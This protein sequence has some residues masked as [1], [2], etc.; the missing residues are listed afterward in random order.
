[1]YF[2]VVHASLLHRKKIA[3]YRGASDNGKIIKITVTN[4][5]EVPCSGSSVQRVLTFKSEGLT[6]QVQTTGKETWPCIGCGD[7][8]SDHKLWHD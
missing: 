5:V 7:A 2:T 1:M 3:Q 8:K 4:V 6:S